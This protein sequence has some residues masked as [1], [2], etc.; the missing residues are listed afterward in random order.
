[1]ISFRSDFKESPR[2]SSDWP[3]LNVQL[4]RDQLYITFFTSCELK[5]CPNLCSN[6]R[7]RWYNNHLTSANTTIEWNIFNDALIFF[8][9]LV[10]FLELQWCSCRSLH[11]IPVFLNRDVLCYHICFYNLDTDCSLK[12]TC[13]V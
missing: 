12:M 2:F 13:T 8:S 5:I 4:W 6:T 11:V 10:I 7:M 9:K 1:M 3:F